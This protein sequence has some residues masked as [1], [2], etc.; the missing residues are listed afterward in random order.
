M[1]TGLKSFAVVAWQSEFPCCRIIDKRAVLTFQLAKCK[2]VKTWF[3][4]L[5]VQP[6]GHT[7][8]NKGGKN[9]DR[10]GED[11]TDK[12]PAAAMKRHWEMSQTPAMAGKAGAYS[13]QFSL[14]ANIVVCTTR[15]RACL[16]TG[17]VL[18]LSCGPSIVF[19]FTK[20]QVDRFP[21]GFMPRKMCNLTYVRVE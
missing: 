17:I 7:S 8:E 5:F 1:A 6:G 2:G 15:G 13:G 19:V 12:Q 16:T 14:L 11:S 4:T 18:V 21:H 20:W 9:P 3:L 10:P